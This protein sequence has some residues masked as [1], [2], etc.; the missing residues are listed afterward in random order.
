MKYCSVPNC[1]SYTGHKF[2]KDYAL[3]M[4]WRVAIR[5]EDSK[6]KELWNP[7]SEDIVCH[8]HF[9]KNDYKDTLL[10]CTGNEVFLSKR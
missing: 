10:A 4:K 8:N 2:P 5:R 7:G 1:R 6:T 3:T 9:N